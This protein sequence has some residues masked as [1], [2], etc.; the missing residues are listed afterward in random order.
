[1]LESHIQEQKN[2][3]EREKQT[4]IDLKQQLNKRKSLQEAKIEKNSPEAKNDAPKPQNVNKNE[5]NF[6][7]EE[8][9]ANFL[10]SELKINVLDEVNTNF[11]FFS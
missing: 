8:L 1:M 11:F 9:R 5:L 7:I 3:L 6:V 10:K 2:F 4:T